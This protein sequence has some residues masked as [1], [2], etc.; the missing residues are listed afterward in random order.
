MVLDVM[1]LGRSY[2]SESSLE[3]ELQYDSLDF[4]DPIDESVMEAD[5][6]MLAVA[7]Q[8]EANMHAIDMAIAGTEYMALRETGQEMVWEGFS[9]S[10]IIDKA[11]QGVQWLWGQIQKF[12]KTVIDKFNS[13]R[14][15]NFLKKYKKDAEGKVVNIKTKLIPVLKGSKRSVDMMAIA[16]IITGWNP[17]KQL[18][19]ESNKVV[20][21]YQVVADQKDSGKGVEDIDVKLKEIAATVFPFKDSS[22]KD[23]DDGASAT[24]GILEYLGL[25]GTSNEAKDIQV[26]ANKAIKMLET[27]V[28]DKRKIKD[29]YEENKKKINDD[30]KNLKKF[31][32]TV[33]DHKIFSNDAS[34]AVHN[35]VKVVQK[36]GKWLT[37]LNRGLIKAM[38]AYCGLA[39]KAVVAAATLKVEKPSRA[40]VGPESPDM[41]DTISQFHNMAKGE[42][43]LFDAIEFF[44]IV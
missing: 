1:G 43:T 35:G 18:A 14:I 4:V 9:I 36:T 24:R 25:K 38:N 27:F 13:W 20:K 7:Y 2:L 29:M 12:F 11:K 19:D 39:R 3:P 22:G 8:C 40:T 34:K 10:G 31:E 41:Y 26:D 30:L 16:Q 21:S 5:E 42:A 32:K 6:F 33:K 15:D 37:I 44:D 17:Y 28:K 23:F